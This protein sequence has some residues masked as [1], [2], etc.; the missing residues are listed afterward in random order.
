MKLH[1]CGDTKQLLPSYF[2]FNLYI[3]DL[4]W[5]V[6][7]DHAR[8][9]L[10]EKVIFAGN[11]NPVEVQN[12]SKEEVFAACKSLVEKHKNERFILSAG[13]EITPLTASENLLAMSKAR[14]L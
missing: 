8:S 11:I 12:I 5:Q 2:D 13:C 7:I 3:L 14:F 10:G 1:I 6:D 9:I 4:D